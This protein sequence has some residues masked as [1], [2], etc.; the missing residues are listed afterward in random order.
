MLFKVSNNYTNNYTKLMIHTFNLYIFLLSY[1]RF[2]REDFKE[3]AILNYAFV[4][5]N[6]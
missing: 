4:N 2:I 1:S 5:Y 6:N 3:F